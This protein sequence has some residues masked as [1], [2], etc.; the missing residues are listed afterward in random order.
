MFG[1]VAHNQS[2]EQIAARMI[3]TAASNW[4]IDPGALHTLD[5]VVRMLIEACAVELYRLDNELVNLQKTVSERLATLLIPDVYL[6]ALPAGAIIHAT[7]MDAN[8]TAIPA[9]QFV[10]T[11]KITPEGNN[12]LPID[13]PVYMSPAGHYKL[14]NAD[15]QYLMTTVGLFKIN[16]QS[17]TQINNGY[18]RNL[19]NN[20][21]W[22][23]LN[24][25]TSETINIAHT[26]LYFAFRNTSERARLLGT[27]KHS[28]C[29]IGGQEVHLNQGIP[30]T[31]NNQ[32]N[33]EQTFDELFINNKIEREV[34]ES[35]SNY[36]LSFPNSDFCKDI[37][38]NLLEYYPK[39]WNL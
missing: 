1:T 19:Q 6:E 34:N 35:V 13:V 33:F 9:D 39:E 26:A 8:Y 37:N 21:V 11:K 4:G 24:V 18:V 36:F 31:L 28:K 2:K 17:K 23:A 5:P 14:I 7:A 16:K 15:V 32:N 27:L 20:P 29:F 10:C 25:D 3:K 38:T 30:Y 22:V 12:A